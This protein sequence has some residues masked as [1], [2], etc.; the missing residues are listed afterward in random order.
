MD[1]KSGIKKAKKRRMF[2]LFVATLYVAVG[3]VTWY[4]REEGDGFF[5]KYLVSIF[6]LVFIFIFLGYHSLVDDL[7]QIEKQFEELHKRKKL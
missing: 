6:G 5:D 1:L 3:M 7:E 4:Y 2:Y